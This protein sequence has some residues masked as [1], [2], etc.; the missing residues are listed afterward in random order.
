MGAPRT[1]A[2]GLSPPQGNSGNSRLQSGQE[3]PFANR[4]D[5]RFRQI[6]LL[7]LL[8]RQTANDR[9]AGGHFE[10]DSDLCKCDT[11]KG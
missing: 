8:S 9:L 10:N 2:L 6:D 5:L 7:S 1:T 11:K 4:K 3:N